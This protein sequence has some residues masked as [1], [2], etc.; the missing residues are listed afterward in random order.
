M[1]RPKP[2]WWSGTNNENGWNYPEEYTL[3]DVV[4]NREEVTK[5]PY[6]EVALKIADGMMEGTIDSLASEPGVGVIL[7]DSNPD[8][9]TRIK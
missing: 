3:D 4:H 2:L 7:E 6:L 8:D 9:H 1:F 5:L